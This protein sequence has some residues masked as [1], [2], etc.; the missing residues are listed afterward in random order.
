MVNHSSTSFLLVFLLLF[1]VSSFSQD[2][3]SIFKSKCAVCHK[4]TNK[5]FI[6]PGLA[7]VH[8]KYTLDWFKKFV[9]SSQTLIKN[10]DPD[11]VKIFEEFNKVI[12][13]DQD[14]SDSD[15]V[16]LYEYIKSMSPAKTD[17]ASTEAVEEEVI[18]FIPTE[19]DKILGRNLFSGIIRLENGGPSCISCHNVRNDSIVSGGS[20]AKDLTDSFNRLGKD[21]VSSIITGL[22]FPQMKMSYTEHPVTEEEA[23]KIAAFLKDTGEQYYYQGVTSYQNTLLAWGVAGAAVLMGIFPLF[24]Y[25]RKKESVNKRIYD[26]QIKSHN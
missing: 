16:L 3:E 23:T 14:V 2:G 1:S 24:W 25:K 8:E 7:N 26:R 4:L 11:A 20:L 19:E 10:N 9:P 17:I 6:G 22:P 18:P 21:G 12:M 15:L 13:P 5:K